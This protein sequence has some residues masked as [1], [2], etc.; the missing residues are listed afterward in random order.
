[1][2]SPKDYLEI[3]RPVNSF[4]VGAAIIVGAAI[5]GGIQLLSNWT[6]LLYSFITG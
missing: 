3:M 1:M 6:L 4:M 2:G 5:T